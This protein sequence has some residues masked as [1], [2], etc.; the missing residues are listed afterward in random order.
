MLV[1]E[2]VRMIKLGLVTGSCI[3]QSLGNSLYYL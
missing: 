3:Q 1:P 2:P